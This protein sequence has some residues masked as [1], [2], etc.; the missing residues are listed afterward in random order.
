MQ[1][2]WCA[3]R[4]MSRREALA[5]HCS[6]LAGFDVYLPR[7][8]ERRISRGRKIEVRAPLFP[9]YAFVLIV[10]QW[11]QARWCP[12]VFNLIMAGDGPARVPDSV[13]SEIQSRERDGLIELPK[14]PGLKHGDAV[15]VTHG[16]LQGLR[17]LYQA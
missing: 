7:L 9:G 5:T 6:G 4:L 2:F 15:R 17:G 8:R 11:H 13:I 3:A 14:A 12:G 10:L 1:S 16:P